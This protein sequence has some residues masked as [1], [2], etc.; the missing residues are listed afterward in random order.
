MTAPLDDVDLSQRVSKAEALSRLEAAPRHLL[1]LRL[2]CGG[3]LEE[4]RL[5]PPL[6]VLLEGWDASGK[7][8]AIRR[9]VEP[10]DPRHVTVAPFAAPTPRELRHQFFWRFFPSLPGWGG[11]TVLDRSWYGRVL[12]ERCEQL[13]DQA[14]WE[15]AY[16]EINQIEASLAAEGMVIVKLFLHISDDEQLRRFEAR[17]KDPLKAWKLTDEDWRNRAKRPAYEAA[18]N[19]M[20]ERTSTEAAPWELIPAESKPTARLHVIEAVIRRL[21]EG[22][23]LAGIEPPASRGLRYSD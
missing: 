8:G 15:R 16:V 4:P 2:Y 10:L 18:I 9:L 21:E 3:L 5:G 19:E 23:R 7:G 17:A 1:H 6:L 12:V 13:I 11:M 20:V 14:T 22:M